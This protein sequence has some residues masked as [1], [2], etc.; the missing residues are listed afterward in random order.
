MDTNL[1]NARQK[2]ENK[3]TLKKLD[4]SIFCAHSVMAEQFVSTQPGNLLHYCSFWSIAGL[5]L[6][7]V[8]LY[9]LLLKYISLSG[10]WREPL[11]TRYHT[12]KRRFF[13]CLLYVVV[14]DNM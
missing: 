1:T 3:F 7:S 9:V 10:V 11:I 14:S 5:C 13:T 6:I 8:T 4:N 2:K 12:V